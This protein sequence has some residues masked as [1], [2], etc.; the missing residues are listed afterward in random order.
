MK[1]ATVPINTLAAQLADSLASPSRICHSQRQP[2]WFPLGCCV[3]LMFMTFSPP[4]RDP[5]VTTGAVDAVALAKVVARAIV[6]LGLSVFILRRWNSPRRKTTTRLLLPWIGFAGWAV[7]STVWSPLKAVT[8]GQSA[9]FVI[10]LLLALAIAMCFEFAELE[11]ML[12]G[13]TL[14]LLLVC[15]LLLLL[16]FAVPDWGTLTRDGSGLLHATNSSATASI[17]CVIL[18]GSRFLYRWKWSRLFWLPGLGLFATTLMLAQSRTAITVTVLVVGVLVVSLTS[19]LWRGLASAGFGLVGTLYLITD[20]QLDISQRVLA[21]LTTYTV[22]DQSFEELAQLSGRTEMWTT[23]WNSFLESPWIGHGYFV[24]SASGE[25]FAWYVWTNWTAHNFWLQVLVST[26]LIGGLML[27]CGLLQL[28]I[29][30][31]RAAL[32]GQCEWQFAGLIGAVLCW[33]MG[34]GANNESF[35]GPLQPESVIFF[36]ILGLAV[37]R[38]SDSR[39]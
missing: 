5:T 1:Q 29:R 16:Y 17:G 25:I 22:R 36:A 23:I 21:A 31:L 32:C 2:I 30:S 27:A 19:T 34:W 37:G 11:Y 39:T 33:Q 7:V 4:Q 12:K 15:G 6:L 3:L 18:A 28:G 38:F 35:V 26:G 10:L 13:L 9:S 24:S 8:L 20:L 14:A